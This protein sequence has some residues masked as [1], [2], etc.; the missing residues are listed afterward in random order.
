M[1]GTGNITQKIAW[2]TLWFGLTMGMAGCR[3]KPQL[4]P[5][6]PVMSPVAL[7]DIPEPDDLPM[8]EEPPAKLPTV[9]VSTEAGKP[10]KRKKQPPKVIAP[11]EP[12][13]E[14][15][16]A[17]A[18]APSPDAA[19]GALTAGGETNPQ[20]KQDAEELIASIDKRLNALPAQKVEE[21]KAQ[22]SKVR[23]FWKDAQDALKSGDAEGAKTL[24]TKAK[25]LL[26]D[27]EK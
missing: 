6:P 10:K 8:V 12:V 5:L 14:T 20:T 7:E 1:K 26:D 11:P 21:Q 25:L 17:S 2:T 27:L 19:V 13:S 3:H 15:Q 22:V 16:V 4:A 18:A 24:A 23:N 9:P